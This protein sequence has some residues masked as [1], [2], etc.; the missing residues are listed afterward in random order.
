[1]CKLTQDR[2]IMKMKL[3]GKIA[4]ITGGNSGI[5]LETAKLLKSEGARLALFGQDQ[6]SMEKTIR[7]LGGSDL[8]FVGDVSSIQ[9]LTLFVEKIKEQYGKIDI[10]FINAGISKSAAINEVSESF[11]DKIFNT[12]VKGAFFSI[13][14]AL[15]LMGE[16]SSIVVTTS[17]VI[18]V[19]YTQLSTYSASKGAL[20]AL[21]RSAA[22]EL[23]GHGIRINA[24]SPGPIETSLLTKNLD[25]ETH[26]AVMKQIAEHIPMK[27]M[28]KASEVAKAVLFLASDDST[29]MTG[30]ELVIDGGGRTIG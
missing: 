24:V 27:R 1:M 21:V 28:G 8:G 3:E 23:I 17:N 5:G 12:N 16:G 9:D 30:E 29:F 11:Y 15:P 26:I 2:S 7:E 18:H 4:V 10:L 22:A 19:G 6:T 20:G 25:K 13:Q 14:K